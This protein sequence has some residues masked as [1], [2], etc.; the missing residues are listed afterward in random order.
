MKL[1]RIRMGDKIVDKIHKMVQDNKESGEL[2][3]YNMGYLIALN[4]V[5]DIIDEYDN[6]R[7]MFIKINEKI[8][9]LKGDA[10]CK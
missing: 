7:D 6:K 9:L 1:W 8:E 3:F 2:S 10:K 5:F 4:Q